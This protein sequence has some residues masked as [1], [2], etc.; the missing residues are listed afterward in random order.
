MPT[1][2]KQIVTRIWTRGISDS[3][4]DSFNEWVSLSSG[5]R[6]FL[7]GWL[8]LGVRLLVV[9][10][11]A[12]PRQLFV[13]QSVHILPS[14][15][16]RDLVEQEILLKITAGSW[17]PL[18]ATVPTCCSVDNKDPNQVSWFSPTNNQFIYF[19]KKVCYSFFGWQR[20]A[21]RKIKQHLGLL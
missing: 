12:S 2:P 21:K 8:L 11:L 9:L 5:V 10:G 19:F 20:K 15:S 16:Q 3:F 7:I 6:L 4:K 14:H 13:P 17:D 1:I 18:E